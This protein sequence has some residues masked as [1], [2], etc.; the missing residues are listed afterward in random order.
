VG[1]PKKEIP[2]GVRSGKKKRIQRRE[3]QS[4]SIRSNQL[5]LGQ[6][7]K[8]RKN[9]EQDREKKLF[10]TTNLKKNERGQG[11]WSALLKLQEL[12]GTEKD[13]KG[14][15]GKK[16]KKRTRP[17]RPNSLFKKTGTRWSEG[18]DPR[19]RFRRKG[20]SAKKKKGFEGEKGA[21]GSQKDN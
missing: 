10:G 15:Q 3:K 6:K 21:V 9:R 4:S 1:L 12:H 13:D 7:A 16:K 19:N 5:E 14:G 2:R 11:R 20:K 18:Q 17:A 8:R